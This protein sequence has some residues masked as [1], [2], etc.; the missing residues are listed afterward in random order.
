MFECHVILERIFQ[1]IS[2]ISKIVVDHRMTL[3]SLIKVNHRAAYFLKPFFVGDK[4]VDSSSVVAV[5]FYWYEMHLR[6]TEKAFC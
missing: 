6:I 1:Q 5:A 3:H 4:Q 2:K